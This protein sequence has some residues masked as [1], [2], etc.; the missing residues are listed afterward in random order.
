MSAVNYTD[1]PWRVAKSSEPL[2]ED[3]IVCE[4]PNGWEVRPDG[5]QKLGSEAAD[6]RLIASAPDLLAAL[7]RFID[8]EAALENHDD[9]NGLVIYAQFYK[10]ARAAITKATTV[11]P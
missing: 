5:K 6:L 11:V 4:S 7:E 2:T 8:Y 1:G 10:M 3:G 9:V